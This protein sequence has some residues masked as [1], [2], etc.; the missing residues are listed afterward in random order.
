MN[1]AGTHKL[2]EAVEGQEADPKQQPKQ[3]GPPE[4]LG[5]GSTPAEIAEN[6]RR[7]QAARS[8]GPPDRDDYLARVGRGQQTHG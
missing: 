7:E 8:Q 5:P 3:A 6:A 1:E 4:P 2:T